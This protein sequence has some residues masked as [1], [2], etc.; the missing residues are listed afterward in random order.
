MENAHALKK[1]KIYSDDFGLRG[2]VTRKTILA[3]KRYTSIVGRFV[4][5]CTNQ[6]KGS[7]PNTLYITVISSVNAPWGERL[8]FTERLSPG[9]KRPGGF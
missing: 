9:R 1:R 5:G 3:Q 4:R 6:A 7:S 2:L 8:F